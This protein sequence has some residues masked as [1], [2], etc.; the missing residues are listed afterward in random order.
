MKHL[1]ALAFVLAAA[2]ACAQFKCTGADGRVSFQQQPCE[3][4]AAAKRLDLPP[5]AP[6]DGREWARAAKA[7][8]VV[9]EG[10]TR[11]EVAGIWPLPDKCNTSWSGGSKYEQCVWRRHDKTTYVYFTDGIVTG[12]QESVR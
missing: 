6:E 1:A 8:G 10:L 11:S 7:R 9:V 5:P 4:G 2:P 3:A 12:A